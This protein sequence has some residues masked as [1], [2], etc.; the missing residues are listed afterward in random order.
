MSTPHDKLPSQI[1]QGLGSA[2][3]PDA[4]QAAPGRDG[5]RAALMAGNPN[6]ISTFFKL[7]AQACGGANSDGYRAFLTMGLTKDNR[8]IAAEE[9]RAVANEFTKIGLG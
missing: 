6:T 2:A 7:A 1:Q 5:L 4:D 9:A 8:D 3:T